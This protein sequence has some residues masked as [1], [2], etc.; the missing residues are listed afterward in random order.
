VKDADIHILVDNIIRHVLINC[1]VSYSTNY[2]KHRHG[3]YYLYLSF[4]ED[5]ANIRAIETIKE[6]FCCEEHEHP[7]YKVI[8]IPVRRVLDAVFGSTDRSENEH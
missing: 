3:R 2:F 1:K 7:L 6:V 4:S 5:G 8:V